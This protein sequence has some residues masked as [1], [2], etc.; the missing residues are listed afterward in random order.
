MGDS[1]DDLLLAIRQQIK[2][3][4]TSRLFGPLTCQQQH[5]YEGLVARERELLRSGTCQAD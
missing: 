3:L 5:L 2:M 1:V 4:E